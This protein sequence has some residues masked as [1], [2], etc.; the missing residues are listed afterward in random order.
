LTSKEAIQVNFRRVQERI[1]EAAISAGRDPQDVSLVT[2]TKGKPLEIVQAAIAA[3]AN[4]LG[5]N[6][7]EEGRTKILAT[8]DQHGIQWHMIGHI[9]SR[10][11]RIVCEH[12]NFAHSLDSLKL[13]R[14]LNR[15]SI[16][17]DITLQVLLEFNVSGEPSKF[18]WRAQDQDNWNRLLPEISEI[19][20]LP[21]I[22]MRGLMTIAPIVS[23]SAE[24]RLYF[25]RLRELRDFIASQFPQNSWDEL[26]MGMSADFESAIMEG[27]TMVRVGSA[28]LGP[29]RNI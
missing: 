21:N 7:P 18:G 28:I 22:E 8:S 19:T 17:L 20:K 12:Y 26:S 6:Y 24:S 9:Q 16:E 11:A 5:E 23:D 27:A 4:I 13:A 25:Q 29:R 2:V 3:G 15:F 1:A 14:R 10:K